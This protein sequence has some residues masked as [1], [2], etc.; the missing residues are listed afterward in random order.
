M[1]P[2][3]FSTIWVNFEFSID[4]YL[5]L[6][7]IW[8]QDNIFGVEVFENYVLASIRRVWSLREVLS[9]LGDKFVC[10]NFIIP[11]TWANI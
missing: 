10:I 1:L 11:N 4:G 8:F 3:L 7:V 5:G 2:V 6:W 9:A